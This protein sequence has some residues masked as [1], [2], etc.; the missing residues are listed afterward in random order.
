MRKHAI[1]FRQHIA[2]DSARNLHLVYLF[3]QD[4]IR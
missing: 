2:Q 4:A 1:L 3:Y